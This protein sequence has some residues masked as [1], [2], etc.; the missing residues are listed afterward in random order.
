MKRVIVIEFLS[1]DGVMQ[2]PDGS[3]GSENG[4]WAFRYGPEAVAG[5]KFKL[6]A[7]LDSGALLLGRATWQLFAGIW[8]S[9]DDAFSSK[10]NSIP[11]LVASRSLA[12]VDEWHNSSLIGG[13]L[14]D[15][16]A[17]RKADQDLVVAGSASVVHALMERDLVDEY[18]LL[19]FPLVLGEG[20]RLFED[21]AAP[22]DLRL[23][24][25]EPA[26][27]AV[28]SVYSRAQGEH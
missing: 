21:G 18:R 6:G 10:M 24:S 23:E 16:V 1:L 13:D 4:G 3:G 12:R 22:I 14:A 7:V 26:G 9:R 17:R 5:D 2:D 27:P 20:S 11:K 25:A 8:P 28:L 19:V 15:E